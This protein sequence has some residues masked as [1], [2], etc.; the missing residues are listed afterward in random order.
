MFVAAI[1]A[2]SGPHGRHCGMSAHRHALQKNTTKRKPTQ[3]TIE[4]HA[5]L[6]ATRQQLWASTSVKQ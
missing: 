4:L 6:L 1:D 3:L 5:H 2:D